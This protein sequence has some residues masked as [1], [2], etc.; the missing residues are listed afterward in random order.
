MFLLN[1][2]FNFEGTK[3]MLTMLSDDTYPRTNFIFTLN[4]FLFIFAFLK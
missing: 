4:I 1:L 3:L 2:S